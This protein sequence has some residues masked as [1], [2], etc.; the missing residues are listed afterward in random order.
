[1]FAMKMASGSRRADWPPQHQQLTH[2]GA[3][4]AAYQ[5]ENLSLSID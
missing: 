1:M 4:T 2:S 3:D 5:Y